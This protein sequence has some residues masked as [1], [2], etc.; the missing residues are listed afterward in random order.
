MQKNAKDC[1]EV[2]FGLCRPIYMEV[3]E[4]YNFFFQA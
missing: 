4:H 2:Q 3:I 1:S